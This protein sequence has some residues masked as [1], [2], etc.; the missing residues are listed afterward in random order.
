ML[1]ADLFPQDKFG[2]WGKDMM[3]SVQALGVDQEEN[4]QEIEGAMLRCHR[5]G[6]M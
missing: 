1:R 5:K 3:Q 2:K 6:L 4:A